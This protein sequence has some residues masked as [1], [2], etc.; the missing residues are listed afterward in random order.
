MEQPPSLTHR[1][2]IK[3]YDTGCPVTHITSGSGSGGINDSAFS[4]A[5]GDMEHD[6]LQISTNLQK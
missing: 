4:I 6:K 2:S 5:P 3:G 1:K